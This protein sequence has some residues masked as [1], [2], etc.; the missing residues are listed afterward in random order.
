MK[1][2]AAHVARQDSGRRP[3]AWLVVCAAV[4][5]TALSGLV[6]LAADPGS[7]AAV[8]TFPVSQAGIAVELADGGV[9][10]TAG[11]R[12]AVTQVKVRCTGLIPA[13]QKEAA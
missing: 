6:P 13:G 1:Y 4:A 7:W 8:G 5:V 9:P 12:M 11:A 3:R 10:A 2:L